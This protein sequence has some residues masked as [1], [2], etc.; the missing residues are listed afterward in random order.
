MQEDV[1]YNGIVSIVENCFDTHIVNR[2]HVDIFWGAIR[3]SCALCDPC[4]IELTLKG[5]NIKTYER[6]L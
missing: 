2:A 6:Y 1:E 4:I 5:V 3:L